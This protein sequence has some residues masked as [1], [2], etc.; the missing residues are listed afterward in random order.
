MKSLEKVLASNDRLEA[1]S[2]FLAKFKTSKDGVP[3]A[4]TVKTS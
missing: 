2:R 4:S 1:F 3:P